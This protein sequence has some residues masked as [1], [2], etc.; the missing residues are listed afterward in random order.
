[1]GYDYKAVMDT[2][3]SLQLTLFEVTKS[4][5]SCDSHTLRRITRQSFEDI[6]RGL[7]V[8]NDP[9]SN[10]LIR[11]G[12]QGIQ[13]LRRESSLHRDHVPDPRIGID[14]QTLKDLDR[15]S[16]VLCD[17]NPRIWVIPDYVIPDAGCSFLAGCD[18]TGLQPCIGH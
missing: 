2:S 5:N 3:A 18:R 7:L 14:C 12:C 1:M 17:P 8:H 16:L 9:N 6:F 4:R 10:G 11:V 15:H 13:H